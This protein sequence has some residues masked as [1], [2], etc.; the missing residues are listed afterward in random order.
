MF[1]TWLY[2]LNCFHI[3]ALLSLDCGIKGVTVGPSTVS[4]PGAGVSCFASQGFAKGEPVG[5]YF[6]TLVYGYTRTWNMKEG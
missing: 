4:Y 6:V 2:Y 5:F 3:R 1:K